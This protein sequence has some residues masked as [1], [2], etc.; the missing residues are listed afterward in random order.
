MISFLKEIALE[1]GEPLATLII[2]AHWEEEQATITSNIQPR[3]IY[4]HDGFPA[5]AYE[6][7]YAAPGYP[8]LVNEIY[9]LLT[10]NNI[11]VKLDGQRGFDHGMF[12]PH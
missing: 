8:E 5:A 4:D 12:I 11:P 3:V 10:V 6:T 9:T 2:S 7:Q 1:L